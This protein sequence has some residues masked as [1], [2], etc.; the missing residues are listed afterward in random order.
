MKLLLDANLS[1]RLVKILKNE[2]EELIHVDILNLSKPAKDYEIWNHALKNDFAIIS[3]DDDFNILSQRLGF[4]PKVIL[5]KT[6]NQSTQ[7]IAN[8]LI[9]RIKDISDFIDYP[10]YGLLEIY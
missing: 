8:L 10:E 5:L 4:P 3:N 9:T 2:F 6:G 1:W 7:Y